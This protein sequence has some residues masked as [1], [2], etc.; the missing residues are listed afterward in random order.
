MLPTDRAILRCIF[1]M[2]RKD[3]PRGDLG[4]GKVFI[5]IDVEAVARRLGV[6]KHL[7]FGRLHYDMGTRLKHR[8][9]KDPNLT[10]ASVFEPL[11]G[12]QRHSVNFPYLAAVLA[13]LEE[14]RRRDLWTTG[15]AIL[16]LVV[17]V[18]TAAVQW[19][20]SP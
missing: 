8:D 12:S 5:P 20:Q 6:D 9:P 1:D 16:A 15:L 14:Q 17:A 2:Y 13:G 19:V 10:L 18:A 7:L 3:F 4:A 11:V